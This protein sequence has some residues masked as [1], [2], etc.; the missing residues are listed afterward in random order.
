[1]LSFNYLAFIIIIFLL[2]ILFEFFYFSF[3]Y[4]LRLQKNIWESESF[5]VIIAI[6]SP[7]LTVT[8]LFILFFFDGHL[9]PIFI[10]LI[11]TLARQ[12]C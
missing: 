5:N 7:S 6:A 12:G 8:P 9:F 10:C 3:E 1:M 4:I 2:L 11:I